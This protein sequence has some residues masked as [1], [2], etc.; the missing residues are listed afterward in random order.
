VVL[1]PSRARGRLLLEVEPAGALVEID[2]AQAP[3]PPDGIELAWG[4]HTLRLSHEGYGEA[5]A[6]FELSPGH[7]V[8]RLST[9]LPR[10]IDSAPVHG[11]LSLEA[12]VTPPRRVS[13]AL[14]ACPEDLRG[15][16]RA[17]VD[18]Y[19]R[20]TGEVARVD[21]VSG[22][23]ALRR[24][25]AEAAATWRFAPATRAGQRVAVRLRVL[26]VFVP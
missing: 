14:P 13:G 12:D 7:P 16:S 6:E 17:V 19:V 4:P 11:F 9:I 1:D 22:P 21:E 10:R 2:G 25:L 24:C 26:H 5:R 23:S 15:P 8:V 20:E 3:L 18:V